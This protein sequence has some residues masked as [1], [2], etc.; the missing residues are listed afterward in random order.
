[1]KRLLILSIAIF[2]VH[3]LAAQQAV[4]WHSFEKAVGLASQKPRKIF[5]DMYTDW[6]GWCKKMDK[7]TF[8]NPVIAAYLNKHFYPV[9]FDAERKDTVTFMGQKFVNTNPGRSRHSHELARTLLQG[10]MSYPSFVFMD[11]EMRVITVVPGYFPPADFEPVLHFIA[12]NAYQ[13]TSWEDFKARF[14]GQ[15]K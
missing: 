11:E 10:K 6:C 12:T 9:K 1:M 2:F 15:V 4:Q 14:K 3:G 7:D 5:I 8:G 13:T